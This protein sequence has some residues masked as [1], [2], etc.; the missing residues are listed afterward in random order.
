MR[1]PFPVIAAADSVPLV[2]DVAADCEPLQACREAA[3]PPLDFGVLEAH[4]AGA[5]CTPIAGAQDGHW[6]RA[7]RCAASAQNP[8]PT[9]SAKGVDESGH[10]WF[11]SPMNSEVEI[12]P[13]SSIYGL[14]PRDFNF[15]GDGGMVAPEEL[16]LD[17]GE[18]LREHA[19]VQRRIEEEEQWNN[20]GARMHTRAEAIVEAR[21]ELAAD[22]HSVCTPVAPPASLSRGGPSGN[23]AT[24]E[25]RP[26]TSRSSP[27]LGG[28]DLSPS[29]QPCAASG[30]VRS[31]AGL[32][33]RMFPPPAACRSPSPPS[34]RDSVGGVRGGAAS[35]M[36]TRTTAAVPPFTFRAGTGQHVMVNPRRTSPS[37]EAEMRLPTPT[38]P[39]P[40]AAS[41]RPMPAPSPQL[42]RRL[43][44]RA[45]APSGPPACMA[46]KPPWSTL[47]PP[48]SPRAT[49]PRMAPQRWASMA[50]HPRF[51]GA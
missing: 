42:S 8:G 4:D 20:L 13:Y 10:V 30:S 31:L 34:A 12:T 51:G 40:A 41:A 50:G 47:R 33:S 5:C 49:V 48:T 44:P 9:P 6:T 38:F 45:G 43:S 35:R 7:G 27:R 2:D 39:P 25:T 11:N 1:K 16:Q 18:V 24:T 26:S 17:V 15:N 3:V 22:F 36:G 19:D 14:H 37:P 23:F 29:R 46:T 32:E 21:R 28:W